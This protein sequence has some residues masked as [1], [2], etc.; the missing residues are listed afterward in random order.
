MRAYATAIIANVDDIMVNKKHETELALTNLKINSIELMSNLRDTIWASYKEKIFLTGISDRFKNYI[1][2]IMQAY[3]NI[4][5]EVSE[6]ITNDVSFSAIHALNIFRIL[7][8]ACT[9]ALKHGGGSLIDVVFESNS[10]LKLSVKDNGTGIT[11]IN[12][13]NNGNGI[14]NMKLRALESGLSLS[15]EKNEP[16][17]TVIVLTSEQILHNEY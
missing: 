12:Y 5:V 6:V 13:L 17:G 15:V 3:P 11:D 2:K 7:Q 10:M 4:H 8:E 1:K 9:N 14:K 16:S